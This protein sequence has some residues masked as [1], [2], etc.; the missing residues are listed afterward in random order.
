M[1]KYYFGSYMAWKNPSVWSHGN[2]WIKYEDKEENLILGLK[3]AAEQVADVDEGEATVL[4]WQEI[5][6]EQWEKLQVRNK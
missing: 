5:T 3:Q 1:S 2:F 4:S 6:K